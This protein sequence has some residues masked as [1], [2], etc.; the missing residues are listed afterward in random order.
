MAQDDFGSD[1]IK[2]LGVP[3]CTAFAR[4]GKYYLKDEFNGNEF[5]LK[6][7]R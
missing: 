1:I 2:F 6:L 5:S 3:L 7:I 4:G